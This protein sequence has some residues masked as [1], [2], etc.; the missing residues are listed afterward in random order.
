MKKSRCYVCETRCKDYR[1]AASFVFT[2]T[3]VVRFGHKL[4]FMELNKALMEEVS[5]YRWKEV[6]KNE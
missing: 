2:K 4:C 3:N 6:K 5:P 1:E